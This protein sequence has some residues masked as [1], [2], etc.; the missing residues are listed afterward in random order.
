MELGSLIFSS[1][2]GGWQECFWCIHDIAETELFTQR[3]ENRERCCLKQLSEFLIWPCFLKKWLHILLMFFLGLLK[4]KCVLHL[5]YTA[6]LGFCLCSLINIL[7]HMPTPFAKFKAVCSVQR[8][9]CNVLRLIWYL[10]YRLI[11]CSRSVCNIFIPACVS[12]NFSLKVKQAYFM[13]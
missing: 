1:S 9:I 3:T 10:L 11:N 13:I 8:N 6:C 2:Q 4:L 12:C 5:L 7:L